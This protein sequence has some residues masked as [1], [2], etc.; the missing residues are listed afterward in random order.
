MRTYHYLLFLF[1][2]WFNASFV[3]QTYLGVSTSN[4][5]GA[6]GTQLQPASFVDGRFVFDWNIVGLNQNLYQNF[7][8]FDAK[9]MRQA[10][11][12]GGYWWK[13]SFGDTAIFNYWTSPD[14]TFMDRFIVRN[15][16]KDSKKVL[17]LYSQ[18][19][20]DL[21]NL[22]FHVSP[23]VAIGFFARYR[24]I[25][26]IDNMDP[27]LAVLAENGLDYSLLWNQKL[28]EELININH[29]TWGNMGS[30]MAKWF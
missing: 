21:F 28:N 13:Q 26:N 22:N 25:T 7:G 12:D 17:G 1:C 3:A 23:R 9:A 19:Q 15:Y 10:Q 30:T 24:S 29:L 16:T 11:G 6:M 20:A 2:L 4:Y 27:K 8:Y 18:T 5:A 14:S